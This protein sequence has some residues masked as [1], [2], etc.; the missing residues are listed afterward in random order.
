MKLIIGLCFIIWI[1]LMGIGYKVIYSI[2]DYSE[3]FVWAE[4]APAVYGKVTSKEPDNHS[5]INY[6]Y[7]VNGLEYAGSS[8]AGA[9]NPGFDDIE[10]GQQVIV[11]YDSADPGK[12]MMGYYQPVRDPFIYISSVVF[13]TIPTVMIFIML[14]GIRYVIRERR[15][16]NGIP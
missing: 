2:T 16:G 6:T 14:M 12:S 5:R 11:I 4:T 10:I 8:R 1:V 15:W 13:A 9:G 3:E 7:K